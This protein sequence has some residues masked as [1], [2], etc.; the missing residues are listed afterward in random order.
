MPPVRLRPRHGAEA[1]SEGHGGDGYGSDGYGSDGYRSDGYRSDGYGSDGYGSDGQGSDGRGS[2]GQGSGRSSQVPRRLRLLEPLTPIALALHALAVVLVGRE[3]WPEAV[4]VAGGL[5]A[6]GVA[7][8][9]GWR[10]AT[11]AA[12]RCGAILLLA[13][14]LLAMRS[15][16]SGFIVLWYFAVVTVYPL[17]LPDRLS[18]AVAAVVPASYL[19]LVPL[20]A[21]DGPVPVALVRAGSLT[22]LALFAHFAALAYRS[23]VGGRDATLALLDTYIDATP[24]GLGFWD[25]NLRLRRLNAPLGDLLDRHGAPAAEHVGL[26]ADQVPALTPALRAVLATGRPVRDVP[27]VRGE[28]VWTSSLYPVRARERLL[29]VGGVFIDVTEQGRT[30]RALEHSATH[31]A[32]TGLPNRLLFHH[33]L[34]SALAQAAADGHQVAVMFCD[35]DRFKVVNDSL[36]HGA[37]DQLLRVAAERLTAAVR[38]GDMVARLGGDEFG[39]LC[40]RVDDPGEAV[41]VA[42]AVCGSVRMPMQLDGQD[43]RSTVSVG[44]TVGG[45]AGQVDVVGML[46]DADVAMYQAKEAGRDRVVLFD[47]SLRR[48]VEGRFELHGALRRAVEDGE[49]TVAYQPV[50]ALGPDDDRSVGGLVGFEAL[51]RW[52]RPGHG[53]VPPGV[54]IG[55]AED[56]GIVAALGEHVLRT[57]CATVRQWREQTGRPLTVAV[58]LSARQL[59]APDCAAVVATVLQDVGLPPDALQLEVT[60]SVLMTDLDQAARGM[61]SLRALGVRLAID[62]FG[63]GYS[64]LA[65]LRDLPVDVLKID[66][67]FTSRLPHD[68]GIFGFIVDLARAIGA[69]TVVEGVETAD[70]LDLVTRL[71]CDH[72]QGYLLGRPMSGL[73]AAGVVAP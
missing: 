20:D 46:R 35:L 24:I 48:R 40:P 28:Q 19:L 7:G 47:Q 31:D 12:V 21:A 59:A 9:A 14:L 42:D 53:P 38:P 36:G 41:A 57:A 55:V 44:L 43:A 13:F 6:L 4:V 39:V 3:P 11:A 5:A 25:R 68:A 60:E 10:S 1:G 23:A 32:L 30:S 65:Y 17:V 26:P 70:Q 18:L 72:A 15:D 67:S 45:G 37:G 22:A 56:L 62:D 34:E 63:T 29:G 54:F 49:I 33:R 50:V 64:S 8:L 58:N 27:L 66:R 52:T 73:E 51:A 71:G 61:A 69:R 16:G 2:D